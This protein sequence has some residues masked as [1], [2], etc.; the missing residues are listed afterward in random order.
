MRVVWVLLLAL[1]SPMVLATSGGLPYEQVGREYGIDPRLLRAI[2]LRES[3]ENPYALNINGEDAH[4]ESRSAALSALHIAVQNPWVLRLPPGS[5]HEYVDRAPPASHRC[6]FHGLQHDRLWFPSEQT[7]RG[8]ARRHGLEV[9]PRRLNTTST[10]VG[11]MQI[12]WYYHGERVS[13]LPELLDPLVN[14]RA[15][16]EFLRELALR[17]DTRE[18]IER[19]HGAS[20]LQRRRDYREAVFHRYRQLR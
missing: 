20:D 1:A 16:A 17:Y 12:N 4:C 15:A 14:L 6:L 7:A 3:A 11:L 2:A 18:V 9:R 8:F 13:A 10:D 19:Y 5:L